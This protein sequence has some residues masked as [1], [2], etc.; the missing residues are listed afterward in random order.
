MGSR[1]NSVLAMVFL[2]LFAGN[3]EVIGQSS[4]LRVGFYSRSCRNVEPIVRGVVQ[5]FLG[6]D[7][8]VTAALLRLFFHDCFVRG[9]D[10]SLLL[11]STRT[12]R[13]EKEHGANGSVRGYDLIDAAKAE[14]ERQCRGVV[15]CADIVAL[16]TRDSI[17][18][19]GG[20][21]YPVPTGRRDGRISI[22]NDANVLPDPNSN[23]NGAIQA[24]ANKG[25][26]PQDLVLLLGAHTV[27]I[28]HCGFFR[29]RLFNFRG[30]G[31]A[32]PSMDPALVRQLQRACTSDSV[33]VFLDQGTP[34]RVD[35]VFFDQLVSNRAILIIDQ[36]LRVE[37][38]T[39]D[40]VRALANGTLNFN[41]AFA[42]SMTNMGNLDVLTGTR[43][44][45]RRVCSAVN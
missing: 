8:T 17:A 20:P 40:I 42:Q 33:E 28:T 35:K 24:F 41:A 3:V 22:V 5:R 45:I 16:A 23:A 4:G 38:R 10:A 34:F 11:N 13:S 7:R 31:R 43:G 29:H 21:D 14:V 19:A 9:C 32:D 18:L 26:T 30:T 25:L 37:Q 27:G 39:D 12:N 15:S 36:Q 44:E 6:R 1:G 2:L